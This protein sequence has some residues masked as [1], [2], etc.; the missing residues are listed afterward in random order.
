MEGC[1]TRSPQAENLYVGNLLVG[2]HGPTECRS[3]HR[4][5]SDKSRG[6]NLFL[7]SFFLGILSAR[8]VSNLNE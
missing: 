5:M 7:F 6:L 2:N 3:H 1:P 8:M 4:T